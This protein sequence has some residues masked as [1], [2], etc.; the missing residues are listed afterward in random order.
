VSKLG[1]HFARLF[2]FLTHKYYLFRLI[3]GFQ[4]PPESLQWQLQAKGIQEEQDEEQLVV[5]NGLLNR[6][7]HY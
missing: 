1:S 6:I 3:D 4:L 7:E 5:K 2:L